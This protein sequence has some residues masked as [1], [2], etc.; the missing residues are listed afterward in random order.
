MKR[1]Q[2]AAFFMTMGIV[3]TPG[4]VKG[5]EVHVAFMS[6]SMGDSLEI[7]LD[8]ENVDWEISNKDVI[9][10]EDDVL[11]VIQEG[12][13]DLVNRDTGFTVKLNSYG[14]TSESGVL[15]VNYNSDTGE[16]D[17]VIVRD[18]TVDIKTVEVKSTVI[19]E[20]SSV[21]ESFSK[22]ENEVNKEVEL[23]EDKV[24]ENEE[25]D[26]NN[27]TEVE[28]DTK[29]DMGSDLSDNKNIEENIVTEVEVK[30]EEK[31]NYIVNS[32][33]GESNVIKVVDPQLN[34]Y[35]YQ[36]SI[37]QSTDVY[38]TNIDV[39]TTFESTNTEVVIVDGTGHVE[40]IG[41]G[42]A[43]IR[44]ITDNNVVEC[45]IVSLKPTVNTEDVLLSKG[46]T[47]KVEV[48]NNF[49]NLPVHYEI[50]SG[51]GSVSDD[52]VVSVDGECVVRTTI[53]NK[54]VYE[55]HIS[56]T[57]VHDE[58]WNAMQPAIEECLGTPYVFGGE[59]PG[60]GMDC[61]AYVSY[62]YRSVG[63]LS[64]RLTAQGLYNIS[65]AT[66]NP[67]PGDLV[68]F[69]GT[70]DTS[71]YI[72]HV[73]IYAGNGEMYHSGN[74]NKKSSLNTSYWQSHIV[75]YGTMISA[76]MESPSIGSYY[77]NI[78]ESGY[79]QEQLELI[80]AIVAQECSTSYEGALA[81]ASCAM[82]RADENYGGYG[83]DILSQLTAPGQFCYSPSVSDPSLWQAR[84]GGNVADFVKQAVDDCLSQGKRNHSFKSFRS[85][86]AEGR[87]NI[88]G[89]WYFN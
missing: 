56:A 61:S 26:L 39:N 3:A 33:T 43:N 40:L 8:N 1:S 70:Y 50:V 53:D 47:Y 60:V 25:V 78:S 55:K 24:S 15:E 14:E 6:C 31:G 2:V 65:S 22:I 89:N 67:L 62:V 29:E 7:T 80:W 42:E 73:G 88:G 23:S 46:E 28:L 57:T 11:K 72:T 81:V 74:P 68:F 18:K 30:P 17:S 41:E 34:Q 21:P 59:T 79:S 44:V 87:V 10:V 83:M 85:T 16:S 20:E 51:D 86:Q 66:D 52:G 5:E 77:G 35:L 63:L 37:G 19:A 36:G 69:T 71:D 58:Y 49:A 45:K 48:E 4:V 32:S 76:D 54:Y 13:C 12:Q 84:L 75:G 64:G 38:V 9:V 27:N 82:N